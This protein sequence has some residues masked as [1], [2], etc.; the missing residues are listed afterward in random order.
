VRS[1]DLTERT[2]VVTGGGRGI[3]WAI[4]KTLAASGATVTIV[5]IDRLAED[6]AASLRQAGWDVSFAHA[7]VRR[8]ADHETVAQSVIDARGRLDIW[9]NN[10][11]IFP[12]ADAV[13]ISDEEWDRVLGIN[14][15][16]TFFGCRAAGRRMSAQGGGVI[17]NLAS[18]SAFR[19]TGAGRS[20]YAASKGAVVSLTRALAGEWG[21]HGVRVIAVA[22]TSIATEGVLAGHDADDGFLEGYARMLPVRRVGSPEE[23]ADVVL[24]AVSDLASLVTGSVIAADGGQ[25]AV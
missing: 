7:D 22:P 2:A 6:R 13:T 5:D 25:L 8:S 3:G 9:V 10:A 11:G 18:V 4:A 21:P 14:V 20:H 23:V 24:F 12:S 15:S 19:V 17:V 16:G 1:I